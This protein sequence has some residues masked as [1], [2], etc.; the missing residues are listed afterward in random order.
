[1]TPVMTV[2]EPVLAPIAADFKPS[3]AALAALSDAFREETARGLAGRPGSLRM[4]PTFAAQPR[5]DERA[6]VLTVDWGGTNGR[7]SLVE[8]RGRGELAVMAEKVFAF[9]EA[10]RTGPAARVFDVIAD[11]VAPIAHEA[12]ADTLPLAFVYSFPARVERIDRAIAL[13]PTKG[14]RPVGLEGCDVVGLLRA[15][16]ARRGVARVAVRAVANDT[17]APMVLQTY[18]VRGV[19]PPAAPAEVGFILGTGTNIAADLPGAGIRNLESGNFDGVRAVETAFDV[20]LDRALT[21]PA[22]RA[23]RLE[24]MVSGRYLGEIVRRVVEHV[25]TTTGLLRWSASEAFATPF[26]L[27]AESLSRIAA[28]RSEALAGV[29]ALL[30][31]VGV[32]SSAEERWLLRDLAGLVV[33]RSARLVAACL[34]GTVRRIDPDL[35]APHTVAVDGSLYGGYPGY[36]RLVGEAFV[37]LL[38]PDRARQIHLEYLRDSTGAGAAVIAAVASRAP[39]ARWP[40]PIP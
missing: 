14:W 34:T 32:E 31:Q 5:G 19:D 29:Q 37:E 39:G 6:R 2:L 16:L 7:V 18:R 3:T 22:P 11:A 33:G 36:D 20:A 26:G 15:A 8:L 21:D 1:M 35:A 13:S 38:G 40:T 12:R 24:K 27:S 30:A 28:D 9:T 23:Q 4:L 17:V 10:H 25:G